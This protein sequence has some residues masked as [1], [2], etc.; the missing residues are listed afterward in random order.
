MRKNYPLSVGL[1]QAWLVLEGDRVIEAVY[2]YQSLVVDLSLY[3]TVTQLQ[4][5]LLGR[6]IASPL[7]ES[8]M[9]AFNGYQ[10]ALQGRLP[11][12]LNHSELETLEGVNP[13][14][15]IADDTL[16]S[17]LSDLNTQIKGKENIQQF[18]EKILLL[19]TLSQYNLVTKRIEEFSNTQ[20]EDDILI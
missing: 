9:S 4:A 16:I 10:D 11:A 14:Q 15:T 8:A 13:I 5:D 3:E 17:L 18:E 2:T 6:G 19:Q 7:V 1:G 12:N 20:N